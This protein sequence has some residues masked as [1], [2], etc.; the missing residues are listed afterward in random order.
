MQLESPCRF[1]LWPP[2]LAALHQVL[3]VVCFDSSQ[4]WRCAVCLMP[5]KDG[6][7]ATGSLHIPCTDH[8][9]AQ[10]SNW[11]HF[12]FQL[13]WFKVCQHWDGACQPRCI[14]MAAVCRA[15]LKSC[16]G[17]LF[18]LTPLPAL[19]GQEL[20]SRAETLVGHLILERRCQAKTAQTSYGPLLHSNTQLLKNSTI[21][22]TVCEV[23]C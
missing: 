6:L 1:C 20:C 12:F 11:I 10:Y 15:C 3:K 14:R 2:W 23:L 19:A 13:P 16:S 8:R 9:S 21:I 4:S 22:W 5:H 18:R 7:Q 17:K